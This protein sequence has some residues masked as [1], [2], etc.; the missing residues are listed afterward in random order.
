MFDHNPDCGNVI[1]KTTK[2][3]SELYSEMKKLIIKSE[4]TEAV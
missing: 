2:H 1:I 3:P 4:K